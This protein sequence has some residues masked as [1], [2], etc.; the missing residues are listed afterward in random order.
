MLQMGEE[1][2]HL[3]PESQCMDMN[4]PRIGHAL[5]IERGSICSGVGVIK[6]PQGQMAHLSCFN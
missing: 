4:V 1:F 5:D 2:N 3:G 6:A